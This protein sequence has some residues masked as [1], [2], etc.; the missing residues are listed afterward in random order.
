MTIHYTTDPRRGS[1]G[2]T[3]FTLVEILIVVSIIGLL[4]G[5]L[6]AVGAPAISRAREVAVQNEIQQMNAAI[7]QFRIENGFYPPSFEI[8]NA[9]YPD[10]APVDYPL[11]RRR[12][13][14][15]LSKLS[16]NHRELETPAGWSSARLEVWWNSVGQFLNQQTSLAFWLSG[17]VNNRQYPLTGGFAGADVVP[18]GFGV[19]FFVGGAQMSDAQ[20]DQ[21]RRRMFHQVD[22]QRFFDPTNEVP[23]T[24]AGTFPAVAVYNQEFAKK[25]GAQRFFL[26]RDSG[27][28]FSPI[29]G[30]AYH[31]AQDAMGNPTE[32]ANPNTFQ[33]IAPGLDGDFGVVNGTNQGFV[34]A[35]GVAANDNIC[36]FADGR[37]DKFINQRQ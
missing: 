22:Q 33:L 2:R 6:V 24:E 27:S 31:V 12:F 34:F 3:G 29:R 4:V 19:N 16:P 25:N 26:Y 8:M 15:F 21:A 36:N 9:P 35:Q 1:S 5:L 37:L 18:V 30:A 17:V 20:T 28:Y 14:P 7:E 32:F 10:G 13:L 11:F 23:V